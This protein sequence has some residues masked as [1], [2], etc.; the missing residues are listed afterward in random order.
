MENQ[1]TKNVISILFAI[2]VLLFLIK[3]LDIS[4]PLTVI[5]TSRSTE[6]SVTGEGK[7]D[8]SPDTAYVDVGITVNNASTVADTQNTINETNN[9]IIAAMRKLG[10]KK[11]DVKT[12]NYSIYPNYSLKVGETQKIEGYNG[13]VTITIKVK[14]I[15]LVSLVVEEST[16]AGANQIQG[17]RFTID[18]PDKYRE[19]ARN[20][21]IQNAKEQAKKLAQSLGIRLGR[22]VNVIESSPSQQ[23]P[24]TL[25]SVEAVGGVGGGGPE[26]QPGTQTVTSTVTLFFEKK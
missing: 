2:L 16:K 25:R 13:N 8:V 24:L 11:E 6:L 18:D 21:A 15:S 17:V 19:E 7:V 1:T 5:N 26:I 22:V 20:K 23:V 10:V 9:K 3:V 4:Y 14:N 12:S